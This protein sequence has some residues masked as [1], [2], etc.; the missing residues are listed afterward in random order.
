MRIDEEKQVID[1]SDHNLVTVVFKA[2][3][4][5]S[6]FGKGKWEE[7]VYYSKKEQDLEKYIKWV[8]ERIKINRVDR[9]EDM[10]SILVQAR[11]E[12]LTKRYKRKVTPDYEKKEQPWVNEE[13]RRKIKERK[14]SNRRK[15]NER[16]K[17]KQK[18]LA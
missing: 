13:I 14:E 17:D 9:I 11:N 10:N 3:K 5:V 7:V 6:G 1:L 4:K 16:N 12:T 18:A 8:E 2:T 15:R